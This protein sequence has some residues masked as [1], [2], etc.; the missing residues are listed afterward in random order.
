MLRTSSLCSFLQPPVT[1]S[2]F[3]PNILLSTMQQQQLV[4]KSFTCCSYLVTP[5]NYRHHP[6]GSHRTV[7]CCLHSESDQTTFFIVLPV[8]LF[9][10]GSVL[11]F[12]Q[13]LG[14]YLFSANVVSRF[15]YSP[16]LN[17]ITKTQN[18][19]V[20]VIECSCWVCTQLS[21]QPKLFLLWQFL[22][23]GLSTSPTFQ[24]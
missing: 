13:T 22:L 19:Y 21:V 3:G 16:I 15:L 18:I 11:R 8:F 4:H 5:P 9:Q 23:L 20:L 1:S 24:C 6:R 14:G 2:L 7:A 10:E 12:V 17:S